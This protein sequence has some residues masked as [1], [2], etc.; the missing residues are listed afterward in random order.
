MTTHYTNI[1]F[2]HESSPSSVI[3]AHEG[4]AAWPPQSPPVVV[5]SSSGLLPEL[6]RVRLQ[7]A[8]S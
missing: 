8:N 2:V 3:Q 7:L 4:W 1:L 6:V 5:A